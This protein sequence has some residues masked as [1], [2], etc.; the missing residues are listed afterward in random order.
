MARPSRRAMTPGRDLRAV[1]LW[2]YPVKSL[3]GER[4][5]RA[6]FAADGIRGDRLL[7]V[8]DQGGMVTARTRPGLLRIETGIGP[9]GEPLVAGE[10]W[11]S[12]TSTRAVSAAA[13]GGHLVSTSGAPV[14]FR[15]DLSPV[16]VLTKSLV[17]E[18]GVDFRRLRPNVLIDGADGREEAD[19]V[20]S[21]L[22]VGS[23]R[24]AITKRCERCVM[25]TFDPDTIEQDAGVL[26]RINRDF[27][28][29]FGLHC[30]VLDP[31]EARRGDAIVLEP[32]S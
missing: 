20:G 10:D 29:L 5:E 1:E 21:T 26:K 23:A 28:R 14:G 8:E 19:W 9:E 15:W 31:G 2:R 12:T 13:P 17:A 16:L 25:T 27:D 11:R 22:R 30:E 24:L 4:L 7:R 18:L 3:R 32:A 6:Q